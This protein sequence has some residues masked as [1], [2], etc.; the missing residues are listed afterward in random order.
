[1]NKLE[2]DEYFWLWSHRDVDL[3]DAQLD[4]QTC[5][6]RRATAEPASRT[7]PVWRAA[8]ANRTAGLYETKA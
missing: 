8:D 1:M 4:R 3:T 6:H 7:D 5:L 2:W